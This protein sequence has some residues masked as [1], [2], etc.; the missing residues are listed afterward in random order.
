MPSRASTPT[1]AIAV[2][3]GEIV[4]WKRVSASSATCTPAGASLTSAATS[5]RTSP[6]RVRAGRPSTS[7]VVRAGSLTTDNVQGRSG[8]STTP[9]STPALVTCT[10]PPVAVSCKPYR[11]PAAGSGRS[12]TVDSSTR[13]PSRATAHVVRAVS[14]TGW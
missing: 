10:S 6:S 2:F 5:G 11:R 12:G 9:S 8:R 1:T 4:V 13:S 14:A 3:S 7:T